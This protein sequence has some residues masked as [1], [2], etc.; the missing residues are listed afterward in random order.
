M[1]TRKLKLTLFLVATIVALIPF[2]IVA[3]GQAIIRTR[4]AEQDGDNPPVVQDNIMVFESSDLGP[5]RAITLSAPVAGDFSFITPSYFGD[6]S[7]MIM[8]PQI[9]QHLELDDDQM[10]KLKDIQKQ[11]AER[12]K[13]ELNFSHGP[14]A[15]PAQMKNIGKL[16]QEINAERKSAMGSVLL[17]HQSKRLEQIALQMKMKN[18]G[19]AATLVSK[20]VAE[21]LGIDEDQQKRIKSRAAEIKKE[22]EQEIARVKEEARK[23][24]MREL[25]PTQRKQ[26]DELMGE[27]FERK[28]VDYRERFRRMQERRNRDDDN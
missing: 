25:T 8:D 14:G 17:P 26:L 23:K 5:G 18:R 24:L 19:D 11:F 16:I 3:Q 15:D 28:K 2:Q 10:A 27:K 21:E 20:D 6:T 13:N 1:L 4:T 22:M 9:K 12:M 7:Q